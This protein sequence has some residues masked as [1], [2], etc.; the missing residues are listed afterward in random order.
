MFSRKLHSKDTK[1]PVKVR[2]TQ[3]IEKKRNSIS[4][5]VFS[6][7]RKEKHPIYVSKKKCCEEKHV[8]LLLTQE[9]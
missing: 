5:S 4:V 8:H 9:D 1:F 2:D 3:K 7:E 6:Y